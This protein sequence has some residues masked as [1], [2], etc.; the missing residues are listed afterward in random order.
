[1]PNM[2]TLAQLYKAVL[3]ATYRQTSKTVALEANQNYVKPGDAADTVKVA[4]ML[5]QGLGDYSRNN[6]FPQGAVTLEW[7]TFK[8]MFDRGREFSI[9]AMDNFESLDLPV[10]NLLKEFMQLWVVPEIDAV[11]FSRLASRAG[12]TV[13]AAFTDAEDAVTA[14]REAQQVLEDAG[15]PKTDLIFFFST[16]LYYLLMNSKDWTRTLTPAQ[17]PNGHYDAFD[18]ITRINVPKNRF[19]SAIDLDPGATDADQGGY[20]KG[21][22]GK[23]I[24]FILM[25][26]PAANAVTKHEVPRIFPPA[27]NQKMDA[28]LFQYRIYHDLFVPDNKT[29]GIYLHTGA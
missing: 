25:H 17:S 6:G 5:V 13:A 20:S 9:D 7:Q 29:P 19:Y 15:V 24:N 26:R 14:L 18:G 27:V 23:D 3:D 28:T 12:N 11:R 8:L 21:A 1:M 2:I 4:K 22:A 16:D 10:A